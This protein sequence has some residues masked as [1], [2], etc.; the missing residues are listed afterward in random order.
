VTYQY[1]SSP[2]CEKE[3]AEALPSFCKVP[4]SCS[5]NNPH[6]EEKV[7]NFSRA[8]RIESGPARGS[9]SIIQL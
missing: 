2:D 5:T 1:F 6:M 4:R 7:P 8:K 9:A 3:P